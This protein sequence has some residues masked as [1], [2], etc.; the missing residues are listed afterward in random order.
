MEKRNRIG[1]I[2]LFLI[3]FLSSSFTICNDI[4]GLA[5]TSILWAF[6]AGLLFYRSHFLKMNVFLVLIILIGLM[7]IGNFVNKEDIR[8]FILI[9]I[10]YAIVALYISQVEYFDFVEM[11]QCVIKFLCIVSLIGYALFLIMP[12]LHSA[13]E[14]IN[15]GGGRATNLVL[16]VASTRYTR[17]MGMFWE[18]GA[19]QTFINLALLF[20]ILKERINKKDII[21][22]SVTILTTYSTAGYLGLVLI[23]TIMFLKQNI[24]INKKIVFMILIAGVLGLCYFSPTINS[25]LFASSRNGQS[26]VFGKIIN[27]FG[28]G[29]SSTLHSA[30]VRYNAIFEVLKAF[31]EKPFFGYGYEGLMQR[32]YDYTLGMNTCTF[33]NWFATYGFAYGIICSFGIFKW[34][35]YYS[36]NMLIRIWMVIILFVLTMS[37]NYI[38]H[39]DIMILVV[40]GLV[41]NTSNNC[42]INARYIDE[43]S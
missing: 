41:Y 40:Y 23:I 33:V 11:F 38:H 34:T 22:Y 6:T 39:V 21:L 5:V 13:L 14:P 17:N 43:D 26:T 1:V 42:A 27:Y 16:Y 28:T 15:T 8:V 37:E 24:D 3:I 32:T 25:F 35:K 18:P 20:E 31:F 10:S 9:S 4:G 7:A 2:S 29:N 36:S 30:D 19:Y 12:S